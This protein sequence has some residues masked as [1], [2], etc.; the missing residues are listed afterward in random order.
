MAIP[1]LNPVSQQSAVV[2]PATG[3]TTDV[4]SACPLGI[5]T[6][7]VDF[8]SGASDQVAYTY[9]KLGGDILDIE[10]TSGSVYANYEEACLEY[11]Y[12]VNTHQA[13]NVLG[14][15]LGQATASFDHNGIIKGGDALSGSNVELRY[16]KFDLRYPKRVGPA[17]SSYAGFGG[18]KS[19]YSASIDLVTNQQDYDLQNLISSSAAESDS[20]KPYA[21]QVGN[22][23]ITIEKVFY[24]T[25]QSMWRF[26]GYYGGLNVVG[27]GS[28][29]GYGQYTDDSTFEIV[30]VWQNKMQAMAYEDHIYTR[31]SHYSYE[32]K[33]NNLRLFPAPV[34]EIITKLWVEFT[35]D[36]ETNSWEDEGDQETGVKGI[37]NMNTIPFSNIRYESINSIGKQ[38]IR[39]FALALTKET[40]GQ[41]RSKFGSIPIPGETVNLNGTELLSQAKDEQDKLREEL[42]TNLDEMTYAKI[43]EQESALMKSVN[44]SS[45]LVPLLIYQG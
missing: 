1:K 7:S 34:A 44:D 40:L 28:I 12:I 33:N 20:G 39:R 16:P 23:R 5:Y 41:V 32:I 36:N 19:F 10:V 42:K 14:D 22:N 35:I 27:N 29:Y 30:P 11:S 13:K 24:K 43:A 15:V 45:K 21:L 38:W 37:N 6:G 18:T 26:F 17:V 25:P 4:S 2:L 3:S 9:Q 31:L 8:L